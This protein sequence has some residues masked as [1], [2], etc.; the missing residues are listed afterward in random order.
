MTTRH[1]RNTPPMPT[2]TVHGDR[3]RIHADALAGYIELDTAPTLPEHVARC[4]RGALADA[5]TAGKVDAERAAATL[6]DQRIAANN[7]IADTAWHQAVLDG[8]IEA[9]ADMRDATTEAPR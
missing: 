4:L 5:Y 2:V 7:R 1:N 6:A 9:Y 8:R 3:V